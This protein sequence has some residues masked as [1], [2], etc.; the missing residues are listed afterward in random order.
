MERGRA[1]QSK[2]A[3]TFNAIYY[4]ARQVPLRSQVKLSQQ[5]PCCPSG[6]QFSPSSRHF[7]IWQ[8]RSYQIPLT[9]NGLHSRSPPSQQSRIDRQG[10]PMSLHGGGSTYFLQ[11]PRRLRPGLIQTSPLQHS[12]PFPQELPVGSHLGSRIPMLVLDP[13]ALIAHSL[14]QRPSLTL[15]SS[16]TA[17]H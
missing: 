11:R 5:L 15:H 14:S 8:V 12:L 10:P 13:N 17:V 6:E 9:G 2:L 4:A 16:P 7:R 3:K 1:Q